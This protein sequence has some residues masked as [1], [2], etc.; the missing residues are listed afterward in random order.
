MNKGAIKS[1]AI[2]ARNKLMADVKS[3][4]YL[5]GIREDGI[6]DPLPQST[7]E[8]EYYDIGSGEPYTLTGDEIKKRAML[9][10]R[11]QYEINVS[12]YKTAYRN[13]LEHTAST[14]F[15]RLC[16][17]RFM[18][19]NEYFDDGLRVLSS[20]EEGKRESDLMSSPFDS[21]I[22]FSDT[23]RIQIRDWKIN[24]KSEDLFAFLMK[25]KCKQLSEFLPGLF[26]AED[27]YI[28]LLVRLSIIDKEGIINHLI[29]DIVE[30]DWKEQVQIIG[31]LYQFYITEKHEE[32]INPI[33]GKEISKEDI[34]AATQL[35]TTDW[36]VRYLLDNSL[37]R[38]WIERHPESLLAEKLPYYIVPKDGN[39]HIINERI[40]PEELKVLDEAVA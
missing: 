30:D 17:I 37:G 29:K 36:V 38:Y 6:Q 20:S 9:V 3:N 5:I 2:W 23:E 13:L 34:P 21:D 26:E 14:W 7:N 33:H 19:V 27:D 8:I 24:N 22:D 16:A 40:Q 10:S 39:V 15:N 31:W 18:E 11:L 4:A 28:D 25:K 32:V 35:F 12:N 1:F